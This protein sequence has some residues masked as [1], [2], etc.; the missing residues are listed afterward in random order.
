[1]RSAHRDDPGTTELTDRVLGMPVLQKLGFGFVASRRVE[2]NPQPPSEHAGDDDDSGSSYHSDDRLEFYD[3]EPTVERHLTCP[4]LW[5]RFTGDFEGSK[6]ILKARVVNLF[7]MTQPLTILG[8]FNFVPEDLGVQLFC[9]PVGAL[10]SIS[11]DHITNFDREY[12]MTQEL[13]VTITSYPAKA[14]YLQA[15]CY[16]PRDKDGEKGLRRK[17]G[18]RVRRCLCQRQA[19]KQCAVC[20]SNLKEICV[21]E[22]RVPPLLHSSPTRDSTANARFHLATIKDI[23]LEEMVNVLVQMSSGHSKH[24]NIFAEHPDLG[25]AD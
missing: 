5:P 1:M 7:A 17:L 19:V 6:A 25:D 9:Y 22:V 10:N 13:A 21:N 3:Q 8:L 24:E 15:G 4:T 12:K 18:Q 23:T 16:K 14:P 2:R 11:P 20:S